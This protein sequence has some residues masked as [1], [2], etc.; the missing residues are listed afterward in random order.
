MPIRTALLVAGLLLAAGPALAQD[1]D[2]G[3]AD[4]Y[5]TMQDHFFR[6]QSEMSN[7]INGE[8]TVVNPET[9]DTP[10][11]GYLPGDTTTDAN[12]GWSYTAGDSGIT[13]VSPDGGTSVEAEPADTSAGE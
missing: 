4:A 8:E 3:S 6:N 7:V 1:A 5:A 11:V 12:T 10:V 9:G 13:A 2:E